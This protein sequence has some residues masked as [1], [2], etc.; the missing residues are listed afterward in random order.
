MENIVSFLKLVIEILDFKN[1]SDYKDGKIAAY[2]N[3]LKQLEKQPVF[4]PKF[5]IGKEVWFVEYGM[6]ERR[7][8]I[9]YYQGNVKE[10][11]I[12]ITTEG[13]RFVYLIS[14]P[15]PYGGW[16]EINEPKTV[17]KTETQLYFSKKEAMYDYGDNIC[18]LNDLTR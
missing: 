13:S 8:K 7:R 3:M 4:Q 16:H 2:K 10:I 18:D 14:N 1:P 15:S 12:N 9:Y 5:A 11:D 6:G 17:S